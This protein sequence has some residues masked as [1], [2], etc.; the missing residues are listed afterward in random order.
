MATYHA[1]LMHGKRGGEGRYSFEADD[2]LI[3]KSAMSAL[4][5]FM[6]HIDD[7]LDPKHADW[8]V[9]SVLRNDT[10]GVVTALG[11]LTFDAGDE[12]PFACMI[13]QD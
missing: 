8:H 1:V 2:G 7:K 5:A 3:E 4:R 11:C 10:H 13:H 9:N 6:Q 12:Q